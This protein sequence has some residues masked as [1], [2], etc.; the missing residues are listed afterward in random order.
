MTWVFSSLHL[1]IGIAFIGAVIGEYL[2]SAAGVGYLIAQAESVFD[3]DTVIAGIVLL[4][5]C[6]LLL[7]AVVSIVESRLLS[8]RR[9]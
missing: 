9:L 5:I 6:A 7:D 1:S 8:W 4:T 2:G 3:V